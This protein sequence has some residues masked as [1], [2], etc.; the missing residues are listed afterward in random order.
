MTR[1]IVSIPRALADL[2]HRLGDAPCV[3]SD[4][5]YI[6]W[7]EL[8]TR[9]RRRAHRLA[10]A[11]VRHGDYVSIA[12][13]NSIDFF[14]NIFAVY[15][16]GAIPQPVSPRLT[17]REQIQLLDLVRPGAAIGFSAALGEAGTS[18]AIPHLP[19]SCAHDPARDDALDDAVSPSWKAPTSGGSTGRPKIIVAT[20][21]AAIDRA[22]SA[23]MGMSKDGT[24]LIPGPMY[25]NAPFSYAIRGL[26]FGNSLVTMSRFDARKTLEACT[27]H[28]PDWMLL[29]PTMMQ[30]IWRLDDKDDFDMTSL[31]CVWHVASKCPRWLK[32]AWIDWLGPETIFELY[33]GTEAQAVTAIGGHEWLTHRGSVGRA[34][35]G[36]IR[37]LGPDLSPVPAGETG[38]IFMRPAPGRRS[39]C[40]LGSRPKAIAGGWESLGDIGHLDDDGYLYITDRLADMIVSGGANIYPAE[41]ELAIEEHPLVVSAAVTG[42]PHDDLGE[43]LH[44]TVQIE[45]TAT[46]TA[47]Q[48]NDFLVD[49]LV[50][51][52]RPRTWTITHDTVRDDAGKIR[53]SALAPPSTH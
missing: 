6:S 52:K 15:L 4:N 11:G 22:G 27:T 13:D 31:R 40:Y 48:L 38:E 9:A 51:Y 21:P 36:E 1:D 43:V 2:A 26:V 34:V 32:K 25:H 24:M 3:V 39:Y 35:L 41:V 19:V 47:E 14:A 42:V 23:G 53:R 17:A 46:V 33:A 12:A 16:L 29:V 10:G 18:R 7:R 8:H 28:Q 5:H 45:P 30:R 44:A 49:R 20:D 50:L 37:V